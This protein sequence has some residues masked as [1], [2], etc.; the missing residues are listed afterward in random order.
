M[1]HTSNMRT[2]CTY[3]ILGNVYGDATVTLRL[4]EERMIK[5]PL[6]MQIPY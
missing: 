1:K 2:H 3:D 4:N 6:A 5:K